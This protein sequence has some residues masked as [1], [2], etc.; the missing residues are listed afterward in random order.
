MHSVLLCN[1]GSKRA[2]ASGAE[3]G[4]RGERQS[5]QG[6]KG[7]LRSQ[8]GSKC[9]LQGAEPPEAL[10]SLALC[11]TTVTVRNTKYGGKP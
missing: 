2:K 11:C 6:Y 1:Q 9:P 5:V 3:K 8:A 7:R 10:T 4:G